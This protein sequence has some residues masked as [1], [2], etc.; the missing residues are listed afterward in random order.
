MRLQAHA[1]SAECKGEDVQMS[2][3]KVENLGI[4]NCLEIVQDLLAVVR[5]S[6]EMND[7]PPT[8]RHRT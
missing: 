7:R 6:I 8:P 2:E 1:A 4:F 5:L 3:N